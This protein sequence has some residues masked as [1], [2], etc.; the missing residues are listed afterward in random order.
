MKKR[1]II[2]V[3]FSFLLFG[4]SKSGE[5][6]TK[7]F[8]IKDVI[9]KEFIEMAR[10]KLS[11]T[12]KDLNHNANITQM[13]RY[14]IVF[15]DFSIYHIATDKFLDFN[16]ETVVLISLRGQYLYVEHASEYSVFSYKTGEKL[17][18]FTKKDTLNFQFN[19]TEI[20]VYEIIDGFYKEKERYPFEDYVIVE[21]EA[22][23]LI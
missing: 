1:L 11:M 12:E 3:L 5:L 8:V 19:Y 15:D 7:K 2:L 16:K 18:E 22:E 4:C 17:L 20:I 14:V 23:E 13:N 10:P 6:K 9:T 21:K